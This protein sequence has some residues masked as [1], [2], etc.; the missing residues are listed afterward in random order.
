MNKFSLTVVLFL[1]LSALHA[2]DTAR[3]V[4]PGMIMVK[5][6]AIH[7]YI[8]IEYSLYLSD[9]KKTYILVPDPFD[10]AYMAR[11]M[12]PVFDSSRY[13]DAEKRVY[14]QKKESI[15]RYY[16]E[17]LAYRYLPSDTPMVD[18]MYV[19]MWIDNRGKI[20]WVSPD[21]NYTGAMPEE[22][23]KELAWISLS[24]NDWGTGGGYMTPKKLFHPPQYVPGNY[25]CEMKIIVSSGPVTAAQKTSG[26]TYAPFDIPLNSPATDEQMDDFIMQNTKK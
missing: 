10:S 20:K 26:A 12:V 24:L 6:P 1:F 13:T 11:K 9:V 17:S 22:L 18:T 3:D 2:Q 4:Q 8:M 23:K 19:D 5:K 21:T 16:A 25:Y 14:P 7:P 15:A